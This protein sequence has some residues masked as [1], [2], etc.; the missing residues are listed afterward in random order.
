M[1][2]II[3]VANQKGGVGKSTTVYHLALAAAD[4]G[5]RTLVVD[6]DPQGNLTRSLGPDD[7]APDSVSLADVLAPQTA[8]TI[9]DVLVETSWTNLKLVPSGGDNLASVEQVIASRSIGR[10]T[11]LRKALAPVVDQFDLILID[12]NPSISVL[13][14]NALVAASHVLIV[15]KADLWSLDGLGRLF[16]SISDVR[17]NYNPA[18][19]L[20]GVLV[21]NYEARTK[22]ARFWVEQLREQTTAAEVR[23]LEPFVPKRQFI[24]D[25]T[26]SGARLDEYGADGREVADLYAKHL[27]T[28]MQEN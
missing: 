20:H 2:Q 27:T 28:L 12:L 21:N 18:L 26:E 8:E 22:Q 10:E 6:A 3:A 4:A 15:T 19:R 11:F 16:G 25:S 14:T 17:E 13:T 9:T 7:L 23:M 5:L 1:T 24:A